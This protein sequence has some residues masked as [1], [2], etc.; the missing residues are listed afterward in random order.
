MFEADRSLGVN[1]WPVVRLTPGN[2][3]ECVLLSPRF[4]ALTTHWT[5]FTIP[6]PGEDCALCELIPSRGLFYLA[7]K[8]LGS[9]RLLELG[10]LSASHLEQH[11]KLLHGGMKPG[12]VLSLSRRSAKS[13]V[14]SE[15]VRFQEGC[16]A[17]DHMTLIQRTMVLFK[18]PCPNPNETLESYEARIRG[19]CQVRNRRYADGLLTKQKNR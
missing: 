3:T 4:F 12:H 8:C 15:V 19:L 7:V 16:Q 13:P 18:L 2:S 1:R 17:V 6:C 9:I 5:R 14:T 10:S 11:C